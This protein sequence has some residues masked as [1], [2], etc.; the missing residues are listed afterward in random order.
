MGW[1]GIVGTVLELIVGFFKKDEN[2]TLLDAGRA[3]QRDEEHKNA[4][5]IK[6]KLNS[7]SYDVDELLKPPS[8]RKQ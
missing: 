1:L 3:I 4:Q 5:E 7:E 6:T 8:E 2:K